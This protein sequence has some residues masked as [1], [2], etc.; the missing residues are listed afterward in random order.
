MLQS[1]QRNFAINVEKL[2]RDIV[3]FRQR[4]SKDIT[5]TAII[6][7]VLFAAFLDPHAQIDLHAFSR[8]CM[9]D[10]LSKYEKFRNLGYTNDTQGQ[11]KVCVAISAAKS[12]QLIE[13]N[14]FTSL[15][16]DK[17]YELNLKL[18][19]AVAG[20]ISK[21]GVLTLINSLN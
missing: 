17:V 3:S 11:V 7:G 9:L 13:C 19:V 18:F 12:R 1:R 15:H 20:L 2:K 4:D 8:K 5:N 6:A 16:N 14:A 10:L 21:E